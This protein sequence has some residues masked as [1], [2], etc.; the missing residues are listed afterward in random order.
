MIL[1]DKTAVSAGFVFN[2]LWPRRISA[3]CATC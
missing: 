2:A 3:A 1:A